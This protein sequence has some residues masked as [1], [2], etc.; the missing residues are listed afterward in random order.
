MHNIHILWIDVTDVNLELLMRMINRHIISFIMY[1]CN[2]C[3][4][5]YTNKEYSIEIRYN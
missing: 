2:K 1:G 3:E 4:Y 5:K